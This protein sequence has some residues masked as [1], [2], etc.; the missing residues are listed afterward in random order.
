MELKNKINLY[1]SN[2]NIVEKII[3]I[4]VVVYLL[5]F[6]L[7]TPEPWCIWARGYPNHYKEN[8]SFL[9]GIVETYWLHST[10]TYNIRIIEKNT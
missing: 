6:I 5:P 4:N 7:K 1:I 10:F 9:E 3:L 2:L 8:I